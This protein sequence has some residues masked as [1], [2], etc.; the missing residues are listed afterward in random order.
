MSFLDIFELFEKNI[1]NLFEISNI[2]LPICLT[3]TE[4]EGNRFACR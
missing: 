3:L 1:A 4:N 2:R